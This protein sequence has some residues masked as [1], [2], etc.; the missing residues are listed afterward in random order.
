MKI[1]HIITGLDVGGAELL[2]ERLIKGDRQK[3]YDHIVISLTSIGKV[4]Q[5]IKKSGVVTKQLSLRNIFDLPRGLIMLVREIKKEKPDLIQTWLYHSDLIGGLAAKIAG[6]NNIIW[7]IRCTDIIFGVGASY[8]AYIAMK[9]CALLSRY[10]PKKIIVVANKAKDS[11]IRQGYDS[12]KLKVIQNGFEVEKY[13]IDNKIRMKTREEL[14]SVDHNSLVIG[15]VGGFQEYK[16][17]ATFIAASEFIA[18]RNNNVIFVLVGNNLDKKNK[19]LNHMI[20]AR[21]LSEKFRLLGE[22]EDIPNILSALDLF[23]LHSR[24]EGF[25]NV[26]GEAM[27]AALPCV[28]TNVG[29]AAELLGQS[30]YVVEPRSPKSLAN[31]IQKV[32]DLKIEERIEVGEKLRTRIAKKYSMESII[33]QYKEVYQSI[34]KGI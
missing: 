14:I 1:F 33:F 29:A 15:S 13:T 5:K 22:R 32:L 30:P 2:L 3:D 31:S 8:S 12:S 27:S 18:K 21:N 10:I 9:I 34:V 4:G 16:D 20:K 11:H 24:S 7:N 28:I 17:H 25:P 19:D 23:C 6:Y 26:L